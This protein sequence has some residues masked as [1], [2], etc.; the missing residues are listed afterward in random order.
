MWHH[1][2]LHTV[3]P[4]GAH[5]RPGTASRL[6]FETVDAWL[7]KEKAFFLQKM[8]M[9]KPHPYS[10]QHHQAEHK[11]AETGVLQKTFDSIH[12]DSLLVHSERVQN[13]DRKYFDHQE[14][15]FANFMCRLGNS[16]IM[17]A[18]STWLRQSC[19]M[20]AVL[21]NLVIKRVVL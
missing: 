6:M 18:K 2:Q 8:K 13:T 5:A 9:C 19:V 15:F 10:V 1:W 20:S 3:R 11:E 14:L 17:C 7:K 16:D 4:H 12:R 21:F